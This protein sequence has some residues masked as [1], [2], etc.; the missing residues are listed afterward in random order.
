[1]EVGVD[2]GDGRRRRMIEDYG[3][4]WNQYVDYYG[5]NEYNPAMQQPAQQEEYYEKEPGY[6]GEEYYE[7]PQ[8]E[9]GEEYYEEEGAQQQQQQQQQPMVI[10]P[11]Q[12]QQPHLMQHGPVGHP[13]PMM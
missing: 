10:D 11:Q 1:M 6:E 2:H 13:H 7:E 5:D 12:V 8:G 4:F 9:Q 3:T